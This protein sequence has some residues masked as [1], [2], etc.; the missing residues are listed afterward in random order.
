MIA[1]II[2]EQNILVIIMSHIPYRSNDWLQ[3]KCISMDTD[4]NQQNIVPTITITNLIRIIHS[5]NIWYYCGHRAQI[6]YAFEN[7]S[8]SLKCRAFLFIVAM[9]LCP[10]LNT[11]SRNQY[12]FS[13]FT[14][15]LFHLH[16]ILKIVQL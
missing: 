2:D 8:A 7:N 6:K 14:W 3:K 11:F 13:S 15:K 4:T 5:L 12:H 1:H 9:T 16:K 10:Y